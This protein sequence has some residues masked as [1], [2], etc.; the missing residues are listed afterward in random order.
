VIGAKLNSNYRFPDYF[1]IERFIRD[2]TRPRR[3]ARNS[4]Q[5]GAVLYQSLHRATVISLAIAITP[6]VTF[7]NSRSLIVSI[8]GQLANC[9]PV[10]AIGSARTEAF[11]SPL[12]SDDEYRREP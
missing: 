10:S 12:L 5:N 3:E 4:A 11:H 9:T 6:C 2:S 1:S 8:W 7:G